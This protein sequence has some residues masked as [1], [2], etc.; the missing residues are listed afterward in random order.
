MRD[1]DAILDELT[2]KLAS[3]E[4]ERQECR[5]LSAIYLV[6][7]FGPLAIGVLA[8]IVVRED[9]KLIF[10]IG[11]AVWF[12]I[13]LILYAVKAG[14]AKSRYLVAYKETVVPRL[15]ALIDPGLRHE[16]MAGLSESV[17]LGTELF[18]THPDR[19]SSED[20][21]EGTVGKTFLQLA[22]VDAEKRHTSTD[23]KGNTKTTYV[24]IFKGLLVIA[25]FHKH[26]QGRTFVF[27]DT[28]ENL[29]GNFGR[30]FQKLGG[31]RET[32]LIRLEDPEFEDAFAVYSTDEIEARYILSTS[33]M[34][35]LLRLQERFGVN[36]RI[37]FKESCVALA[38]PNR[39]SFL[40]PK[41]GVPATDPEQIR[42]FLVELDHVLG[43]VE[44]L[45]LNTRIWTKE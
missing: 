6:V 5:R 45:D 2:P 42:G 25:D 39:G 27:P 15:L 33:M 37:A 18:T 22:E 14:E 11:S 1:L 10:I 26:F 36:F 13:G 4:A 41:L 43:L 7:L 19:Y 12:V 8:A 35:R 38:I 40:E 44:E 20:L 17:F 31:R 29:F 3:L 28:A 16:S 21:I 34:Q 23:S 32:G 9:T 30:F 24:T